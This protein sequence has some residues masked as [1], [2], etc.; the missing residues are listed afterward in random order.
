MRPTALLI[1][2]VLSTAAFA[3]D[4]NIAPAAEITT[5]PAVEANR[6]PLILD[7]R[8]DTGFAFD[9][10]TAGD[11]AVHFDFGAPRTVSGLRFYQNSDIYYTQRYAIEGDAEGDGEFELALA[12]GADAPVGEWIEQTWEPVEVRALRL[13]SVEGVSG[14][15]RAHPCL[16]EVEILGPAMASDAGRAAELGHP[17]STI[18]APRPLRRSTLLV[19]G[20]QPP[21]ILSGTDETTRAA[22]NAL[23]TGLS[24]ALGAEVPVVEDMAQV[25]LGGRT[26]IAIGTCVSNPVVARLYYNWYAAEDN[27]CP[28]PGG[29]SLRTVT[30]PYPWRGDVDVIVLGGSD[31]AG[32]NA[33]VQR[34]LARV[35]DGT[36][37]WMLEVEGPNKPDAEA[38]RAATAGDPAPT[39][40]AFLEAVQQWQRWGDEAYARRAMRALDLMVATYERDPARDIPWNEETTSGPIFAAWE[41]FEPCPLIGDD[42][43]LA[44]TRALLKLLY[45]IPQHVSGYANLEQSKL[46]A[47]NHTTFPLLGLYFGGRY[48][49]HYHHIT[50]CD[51]YLAKAHACFGAQA[52]SWKP[53]EDADSY[54]TCTMDHTVRYCLAEGRED[55]VTGGNMARYAD[56]MIGICDSRG[57]AGGFGDSHYSSNPGLLQRVLPM[58]YLTTG[59][60][61]YRWVLEH[62]D[63]DWVNPYQPAPGQRP[64]RFVGLNVFPLDPQVYEF[65]QTTPYYNEKLV[66]SE[67]PA[68]DAWDKIS[69]RESW[70]PDAQYLLMDGFGRGKHLHYDTG[71]ITEYVADGERW[72]ADHDYLVRNSTEH[73]MLTVLR[74]G[75]GDSLVPSMSGV[76]SSADFDDWSIVGVAVPGYSGLDWERTVLW[77]KGRYFV[78]LDGVTAR[79]PG[80][81]DMELTWK[82]EDTGGERLDDGRVFVSDRSV[83][84]MTSS[85][86]FT[87]DDPDAS[88]G[89][90]VDLTGS[91]SRLVARIALPG[92]DYRM[93]VRGTGVDGSHDSVWVR[94]D[95]GDP[96]AFGLGQGRYSG[97]VGAGAA[98]DAAHEFTVPPGDVHVLLV[99]L[100]ELPPVRIDR[101]TFYRDGAEA[102]TIEAEDAEPLRPDDQIDVETR[103]FSIKSAE[104]ARCHVTTHE[105]Q[106]ISIPLCVLHQRQAQDLTTGDQARFASIFY[107]ESLERRGQYDLGRS[108]PGRYLVTG[109]ERAL[110]A[111]D[112]LRA[113]GID[114]RAQVIVV[115]PERIL[116]AGATQIA[117]GDS[118]WQSDT[119]ANVAL[120]LNDGLL[121]VAGE[122]GSSLTVTDADRAAVTTL[123][124]TEPERASAEAEAGALA[125]TEPRWRA[126]FPEAGDVR[127]LQSADLDGDGAPELLVA[128]G[129]WCHCLN[130]DGTIRWSYAAGNRVLDVADVQARENPGREVAL[131]SADTKLHLLSA[132]GEL[133]DTYQPIAPPH[134]QTFG[135]RPWTLWVVDGADLDGDGLDEL[136]T[137]LDNYEFVALDQDGTRLWTYTQVAHGALDIEFADLDGDGADEIFVSDRYGFVHGVTREGKRAFIGYSSIGDVQFDTAHLTPD[138]LSVIYGSS[139]GDLIARGPDGEIAW[140]FDNFGYAVRRIRAGDITGDDAPEVLV[141]SDTGYLYALAADGS[142]LWRDRLGFAVDDVAVANTDG[143]GR[144]EVLAA[145]EDGLVRVYAGDGT[146]LRDIATGAPARL[147]CVPTPGGDAPVIVATGAGEVA[148][149]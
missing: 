122:A 1:A 25:G 68:E 41:A 28:G 107:N 66:P 101:L 139:T 119:P 129:R 65:T 103:R 43:R 99:T 31:E 115:E 49:G 55:W 113:G 32:L 54:V 39:F 59:D 56:Y 117:V 62:V 22:A 47:W 140:R 27:L 80:Q 130:L 127:R 35:T 77:R 102:L 16:G 93:Q 100:R 86:I 89:R 38:V 51:D 121:T 124:Q 18:S 131:A 36:L 128:Q 83:T 96:V 94:V 6:I 108:G 58:A 81:Y 114:S 76:G 75:R 5:E 30:D 123:L 37:P 29:Y 149:Y 92:G 57:W 106:G 104:P 45:S 116:L 21:A 50:V 142:E 112:A 17:V 132:E 82:T 2:I 105:S 15:R 141:A 134:S 110:I 63:P 4:A 20:G 147:L 10:G 46:V 111:L 145:G 72:L 144:P 79:E 118:R 33:G 88:A 97:P 23:A 52:R 98:P 74:D 78:T 70:D 120:D 135:E 40:A 73:C 143:D 138:G 126:Q 48:F 42:A 84:A 7:G 137:V 13:R 90:A 146:G 53:Q 3:Q 24:E 95:G 85:D 64:D 91:A 87:V 8:V 26:V 11:G 12:E 9:V 125:P 60:P 136:L 34:L 71:A 19:V 61:G 133:L 148:A 14:G 44:Y 69:M 109:D 67:V